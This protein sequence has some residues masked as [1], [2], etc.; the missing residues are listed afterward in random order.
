MGEHE[1]E[2]DNVNNIVMVIIMNNKILLFVQC[3]GLTHSD[4]WKVNGVKLAIANVFRNF[5]D[6][7]IICMRI[8]G[9]IRLC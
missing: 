6:F 4:I 2:N 7:I 5:L 9:A 8:R 3:C 1:P